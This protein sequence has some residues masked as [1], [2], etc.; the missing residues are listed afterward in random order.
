MQN[1]DQATGS[2]N[3]PSLMDGQPETLNA[4]L[5]N[6]SRR[7]FQCLSGEG[8]VLVGYQPP[9]RSPYLALQPKLIST[10]DTTS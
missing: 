2:L 9:H 3:D 10:G 4:A 7:V 6:G 8:F 5:A 1:A